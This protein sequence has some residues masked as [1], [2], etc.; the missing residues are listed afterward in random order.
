MQWEDRRKERGIDNQPQAVAMLPEVVK[1]Q[2]AAV[3]EEKK[4]DIEANRLPPI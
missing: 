2:A 3:E 1:P 4:E